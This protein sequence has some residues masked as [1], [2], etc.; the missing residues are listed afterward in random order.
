MSTQEPSKCCVC[1]EATT[2]RCQACAKSGIDLFFCS[3]EHQKLVWKYHKQVCGPNAHP[4][5]YPPLS[6]EE[7][8][9]FRSNA[10]EFIDLS[11]YKDDPAIA[12]LPEKVMTAETYVEALSFGKKG[13]FQHLLQR[14]Q[15][16][17]SVKDLTYT[18]GMAAARGALSSVNAFRRSGA[19]NFTDGT[20]WSHISAICA[21]ASARAQ[22]IEARTSSY[23]FGKKLPHA[24]ESQAVAALGSLADLIM[25]MQQLRL[26]GVKD[27][28]TGKI[29]V[30][31]VR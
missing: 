12:V 25:P 31:C 21:E 11:K 9:L 22:S 2:K 14:L 13:D 4:F 18:M 19:I 7:V 27:R 10:H 3:P 17:G 28:Q 16:P 23:K 30:K 24:L 6:P 5:R 8:K 1:G 29:S 26:V 20:V 15:K